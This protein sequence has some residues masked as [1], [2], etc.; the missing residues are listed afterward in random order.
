MSISKVILLCCALASAHTVCAADVRDSVDHKTS[1]GLSVPPD[2]YLTAGSEVS[3]NP[4]GDVTSSNGRAVPPDP[5]KVSVVNVIHNPPDDK[6]IR[7]GN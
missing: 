7:G 6:V 4:P 3:H 5:Y 1:T 2:P